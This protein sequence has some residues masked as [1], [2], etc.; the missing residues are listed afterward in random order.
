VSIDKLP[1]GK[2]RVR[3]YVDRARKSRAFT[4]KKDAE[5]FDRDVHRSIETGTI[6]KTDAD[7]QTLAELAAEHMQAV[8]PDL[9]LVR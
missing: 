7:L 5:K 4:L 8:K 6:E 1:S 9:E 2:Y 3:Y